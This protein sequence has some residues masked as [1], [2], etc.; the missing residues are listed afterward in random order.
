MLSRQQLNKSANVALAPLFDIGFELAPV[1]KADKSV[2]N[3]LNIWRPEDRYLRFDRLGWINNNHDAF[4]LGNGRV[5]GNAL[6]ATDSVSDDLMAAIHTRGELAASKKEVEAPC[7]GNPLMMLAVSHAFTGP[8]LSVLGLTG[9]GF[10]LRGLSSRGKS[11]I[12]YVATSVWGAR[13]L[14][15]SW[16]GTPSGF[17][18]IAAVFNDTFLNIEELHKADPKTVGDTIYTL[19]DGR[20]TCQNSA[21]PSSV[22][23]RTGFSGERETIAPIEDAYGYKI[24]LIQ[25][26][27]VLGLKLGPYPS[28]RIFSRWPTFTM[29]S[30]A[31]TS[32][33][34]SSV[35]A[36]STDGGE[37]GCTLRDSTPRCSSSVS[38]VDSTLAEIGGMSVRNSLKRR[39]PAR[40]DQITLAAQAPEITAMQCVSIQGCGGSGLW[41]LR[42]LRGMTR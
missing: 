28:S 8:L 32:S 10:H 34:P 37:V 6:V 1:E 30:S 20:G 5:I 12:Q 24:E 9:G 40:S 21:S 25:A 23:N 19:A 26:P 11:T 7:V 38:R 39:G 4:V 29:A 41:F 35:R 14:L 42:T 15:Q 22:L 27:Y 33:P 17:Q 2:L 16:D 31:G 3:F 36:Y 13:S 18:G